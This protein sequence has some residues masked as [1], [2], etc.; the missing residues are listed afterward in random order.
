MILT[1]GDSV[2]WG[3]GLLDAHKFDRLF[4][5]DRPLSRLAHSG[6]VVGS[7][8]DTSTQKLHPEIPVPY[9]SNWQ[10]LG[11]VI[12]WS[13]VEAVIIN[14]NQRCFVDSDT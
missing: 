9:P 10:Q 2:T 1:L 3:Q 5:S 12:D 6:A 13:E 8:I 11:S 7:E 4:A 14:G